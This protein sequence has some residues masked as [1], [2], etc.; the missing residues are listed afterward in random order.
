MILV[1]QGYGE[2]AA[3]MSQTCNMILPKEYASLCALGIT[4]GPSSGN[5]SRAAHRTAFL[6]WSLD[7]PFEPLSLVINVTHSRPHKL[8]H[9]HR[10]AH[11]TVRF[12][13]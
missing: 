6:C 12:E 1:H 9:Q 7:T 2:E 5:S 4:C 8:S 10:P 13:T 3:E 11:L